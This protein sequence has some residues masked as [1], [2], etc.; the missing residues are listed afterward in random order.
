M[1][2]MLEK[3]CSH[4]PE[5]APDSLLTNTIFKIFPGRGMLP[6]LLGC[7]SV[8]LTI[9][10]LLSTPLYKIHITLLRRFV[11]M[12]AKVRQIIRSLVT[13]VHL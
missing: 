12:T 1:E 13:V 8:S 9:P 2:K 6:D 5:I 10:F 7:F 4:V 11:R 3:T